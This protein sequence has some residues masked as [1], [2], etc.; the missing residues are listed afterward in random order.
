MSSPQLHLR[1]G[2]RMSAP[3]QTEIFRKF[4]RRF[5][6]DDVCLEHLLHVRFD[7]P[8]RCPKCHRRSKLHR[9]SKEPAFVCQWCGNHIHPMAGTAFARTRV[10][11]QIWYFLMFL[12]CTRTKPLNARVIQR[13]IGVTY[14]TAWRMKR[15]IA[16]HFVD[17]D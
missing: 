2:T 17:K 11:L 6:T 9:L 12:I 5:P 7:N 4:A 3:L 14:K 13:E 1:F 15:E 10:S 8:P 16:R